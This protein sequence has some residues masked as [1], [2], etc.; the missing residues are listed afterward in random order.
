MEYPIKF[1]SA[2]WITEVDTNNAVIRDYQ[3]CA[4]QPYRIIGEDESHESGQ[5]VRFTRICLPAAGGGLATEKT[6]SVPAAAL[7]ANL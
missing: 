1:A 5:G 7:N 6:F 2:T 4:G 3:A